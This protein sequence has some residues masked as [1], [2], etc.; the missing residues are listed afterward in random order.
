MVLTSRLQDPAGIDAQVLLRFAAPRQHF[1]VFRVIHEIVR[2]E[3]E[4]RRTFAEPFLVPPILQIEQLEL[5]VFVERNDVGQHPVGRL[6]EEI[7]H[8]TPSRSPV[9]LN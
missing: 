8:F 5:A 3:Q 2:A 1:P 6:I 4:P 9:R 7:A